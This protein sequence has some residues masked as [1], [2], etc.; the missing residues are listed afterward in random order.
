MEMLYLFNIIESVQYNPP[1][2]IAGDFRDS[3]REK[4]FQKLGLEYLLYIYTGI[5]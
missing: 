4:F 1:L 2:A 5:G 3:S